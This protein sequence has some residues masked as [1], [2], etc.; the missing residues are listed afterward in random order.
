MSATV[1]VP[2]ELLIEVAGFLDALDTLAERFDVVLGDNPRDRAMELVTAL[3][4]CVPSYVEMSEID[5]DTA[6]D[7]W[8]AHPVNAGIAAHSKP[9]VAAFMAKS[10]L[11]L[12]ERL[13]Y[14]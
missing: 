12:V 2:T 7:A 10:G 9:V 8:N 11:R 3:C 6:D 4:L 5:D 1:E 14:V 13:E